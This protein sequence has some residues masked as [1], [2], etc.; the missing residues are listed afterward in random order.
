MVEMIPVKDLSEQQIQDIVASVLK[1]ETT[2][3]EVKGFSDQQMEAIYSLAFNLYQNGKYKD[4]IEVFTW[5]GIMNP[6]VSKYWMGLGASL[7][8]AKDFSNALNAYAVA[9]ITSKPEDPIPHLHAGECYLGLGNKT[10]ALKAF[11]MASDYSQ[12]KPQYE[13]VFAK[14]QVFKELIEL[15]AKEEE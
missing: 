4:A 9:A 11:K 15:K 13:K 5:L 8:M 1:G 2:L 7:Q 10:E 14:A 3:Q 12:N 6:F